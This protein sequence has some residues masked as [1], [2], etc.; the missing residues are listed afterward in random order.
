M[1]GIAK[2]TLNRACIMGLLKNDDNPSKDY[3][4]GC[5]STSKTLLPDL[6]VSV[7]RLVDGFRYFSGISG[8]CG[9]GGGVIVPTGELTRGGTTATA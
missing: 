6:T 3:F 9:G 2:T 5:M 7:K 4:L 1:T 8:H